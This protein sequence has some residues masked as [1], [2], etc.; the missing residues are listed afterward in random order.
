MG[1]PRMRKASDLKAKAVHHSQEDA[2]VEIPCATRKVTTRQLL[3][4]SGLEV[5]EAHSKHCVDASSNASSAVQPC[6]NLAGKNQRAESCSA[7][8]RK[9]VTFSDDCKKPSKMPITSFI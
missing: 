2:P 8:R 7:I 6:S 3:L 5:L 4:N 9:R 1:S